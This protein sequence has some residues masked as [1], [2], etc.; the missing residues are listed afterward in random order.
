M[1]LNRVQ[2]QNYSVFLCSNYVYSTIYNIILNRIKKIKIYSGPSKYKSR[3]RILFL[4][5]LIEYVK[6]KMQKENLSKYFTQ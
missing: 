1:Y 6:L 3:N 2:T 4:D 5:N